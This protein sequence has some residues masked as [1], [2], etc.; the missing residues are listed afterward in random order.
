MN[1]FL[2]FF[3]LI[4]LCL[5]LTNTIYA[6]EEISYGVAQ[7][8]TIDDTNVQ[9]GQLV[10]S[11]KSGF[12]I[13]AK[14]YDE[15]IYGVTAQKPAIT[16]IET[17]NNDNKQQV[18]T[19]GNAIVLVN[20]QNG[21]IFKG[22]PI[23]SSKAKGVGMKA[24]RPGVI[25]GTAL[26][27]YNP[28]DPTV[29]QKISVQ[30][31][32]RFF[33]MDVATSSFIDVFKLSMFSAANEQPPV[34]FK[35]FTAGFTIMGSILLGFYFF[36]RVA[37]KGIE[38]LGRNPLASRMIQVGII[39]NVIITIATIVCGLIIAIVILRL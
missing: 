24:K 11:S 29:A 35:Y 4:L 37:A 27:N 6:A 39:I 21:P 30:V 32:I 1:R 14:E 34:F 13:S 16:F 7:Y 20:G 36:G 3:P 31:D 19:S 23:T 17:A 12:S 28:K 18:V 33:S 25:I 8:I 5:F 2:S 22:D 15:N 38:A 9:N 26:E 10:T